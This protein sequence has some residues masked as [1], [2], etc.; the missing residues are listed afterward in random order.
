[1][2]ILLLFHIQVGTGAYQK[3]LE[4]A[5]SL[6]K[7]GCKVFLVVTS[8]KKRL[9]IKKYVY[10]EVYIY[11]APDLLWGKLRQGIDPWNIIVR[12]FSLLFQK[13][14]VIHAVDCRPVV[15]IPSLILKTMLKIPL[16]IS[17]W[18]LFGSGGTAYERSGFFY[19]KTVGLVETFFE[20]YFR[21]FA[22]HSIVVTKALEEKLSKLNYPK[23][24]ISI[25]RVGCDLRD[26]ANLS[27]ANLREDSNYKSDER[28][29]YCL[30]TLFK[31]DLTL[32]I[33]TLKILKKINITLPKV[34]ITGN[35]NISTEICL[36]LNLKLTGRLYTFD[37]VLKYLTISDFGLLPMRSSIANI[38]RWP[39]KSS[40]YLG[41]FLPI[42][43]TPVSD[44]PSIF[45]KYNLGI[46]SRND[47][48]EEFAKGLIKA[49]NISPEERKNMIISIIDF[50]KTELDWKVIA[51]ETL[52]IY[53]K[54]CKY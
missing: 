1:M 35:Y 49:M 20:E 50:V 48:P 44:F 30:G 33:E 51:R 3:V 13:F 15:I 21:R 9:R 12:T 25:L 32:L 5:S 34:I 29:F 39:S 27:R 40:D 46:I 22:D 16:I 36:N 11:E 18:D 6:S 24:K 45:Q 28:I 37:E 17:W 14:D 54:T 53:K 31:S 26:R 52:R 4:M 19:S 8:K 42:I 2:K 43:T 47:T 38:A 41:S 7:V 23:E 10:D